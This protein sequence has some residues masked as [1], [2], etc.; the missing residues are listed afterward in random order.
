M[1]T[2]RPRALRKATGI[3]V[4]PVVIDA[5]DPASGV[6]LVQDW[7]L[8]D[9]GSERHLSYMIQWYTFAA[10]AAGL[11]VWFTLVPAARARRTVARTE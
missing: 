4:L 10:M 3:D 7:P 1:G 6:G 5:D 9:T 11:W 2:S 8:P